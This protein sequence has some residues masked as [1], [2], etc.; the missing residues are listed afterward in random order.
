MT[1][2]NL[3]SHTNYFCGPYTAYCASWEPGYDQSATIDTAAFPAN[4]GLNWGA[5]AADSIGAFLSL[6]W[7]NYDNTHPQTPV[8]P[9]K[10]SEIDSLTVDCAIALSGDLAGCDAILD[11]FLTSAP[12][13]SSTKVDEVEVFL[14][15][16]AYS[17][18][19]KA[20]LRPIGTFVDSNGVAWQS[21]INQKTT[22]HDI[23]FARA[24]GQNVP[25]GSIDVLAMLKWLHGLGWIS[26]NAYFNGLALGVEV[27]QGAGSATIGAFSVTYS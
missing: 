11:L 19:Y 18:A 3:P 26:G 7:G 15:M 9:K 27:M 14:V 24:D 25:A 10:I 1:I 8:A 20:S 6:G 22:P 16:P 23:L 21:V 12:G 17:E 5:P 2:L 13:D 4:T